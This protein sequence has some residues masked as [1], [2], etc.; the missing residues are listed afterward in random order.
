MRLTDT[1]ASEL[2]A[3]YDIQLYGLDPGFV[4]SG[5]SENVAAT[6]G[7]ERWLPYVKTDL[8]AGRDHPAEDVGRAVVALVRISTPALS[9]RI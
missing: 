9:G 8:E 1:L 7:G 2:G 6:S 5:I 4:R 3:D